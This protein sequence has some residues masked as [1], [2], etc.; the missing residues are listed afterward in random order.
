MTSRKSAN[1]AVPLFI[2]CMCLMMLSDSYVVRSTPFGSDQKWLSYALLFD[3][4]LV[5]P[6]MYWLLIARKKERGWLKVLQVLIPC[7][8]LAWFALP[9]SGRD[10][11]QHAPLPLK[12]L[13]AAL[14]AALIGAEAKLVYGLAKRFREGLRTGGD[15]AEA[16]R[17]S[18]NQRMKQTSIFSSLV[19]N[20]LLAAYYLF[21]SWKRKVKPEQPGI[22]AFSYHRKSGQTVMAAVFTHVIAIEA[23]GVH[24]LV[25]RWSEIA[26]WVLT[27]A[28]LWLIFILWAD[29]RASAIQPIEMHPDGL[30]IRYGMRIQGDIPYRWIAAVD[31][32]LEFHPS[33]AESKHS[34]LPMVTPNVKITLTETTTVQGLLFMPK[35]V[36]SIYLALDEPAAFAHA[37]KKMQY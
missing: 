11:L 35:Q 1:W 32:A 5:I 3:F 37:V 16:L 10:L 34:V 33:K 18:F 26:A 27:A 20:D 25:M 36:E 17:L 24:V 13:I 31:T 7:I 2:G 14:E 21:F 8:L 12:M 4:V 6:F 22:A 23:F 29:C 30:R 15:P 9:A 28:D 19:V